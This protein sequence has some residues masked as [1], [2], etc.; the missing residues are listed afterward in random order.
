MASAAET[1]LHDCPHRSMRVALHSPRRCKCFDIDRNP[2]CGALVPCCDAE[3]TQARALVSRSTRASRLVRFGQ[4]FARQRQC[5]RAGEKPAHALIGT[6]ERA[7]PTLPRGKCREGDPRNIG[8]A[9]R[10]CRQ[11]SDRHYS[12]RHFGRKPV[13]TGLVP[14]L[15]R[16]GEISPSPDLSAKQVQLLVDV[17]PQIRRVGIVRNPSNPAVTSAARERHPRPGPRVSYRR[18]RP[19]CRCSRQPR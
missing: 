4:L 5:G 7:S 8:H 13:G 9:R 11:S 17:I 10:P 14:S 3:P 16:P 6:P 12:D 1:I 15:A 2:C 18:N 19:T